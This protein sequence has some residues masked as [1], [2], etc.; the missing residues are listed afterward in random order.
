MPPAE[1][2]APVA[3]SS[4]A[5][6]RQ[7]CW[8]R[9]P[10]AVTPYRAERAVVADPSRRRPDRPRAVRDIRRVGL[11]VLPPEDWN[12]PLSARLARRVSERACSGRGRDRGRDERRFDVRQHQRLCVL[13]RSLAAAHRMSTCVT[14]ASRRS[15]VAV[16]TPPVARISLGEPRPRCSAPRRCSCCTRLRVRGVHA[17]IVSRSSRAPAMEN[18]VRNTL[19]SL[20][21]KAVVLGSDSELDVGFRYLQLAR[22][23]RPDVLW[24]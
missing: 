18:E 3:A 6:W 17:A 9:V 22:G 20:P 21:P 16:H 14:C 24:R 13:P 2:V 15:A 8:R 1:L 7:V 12:E 10:Y 11:P 5:R 19:S 23:E 4:R